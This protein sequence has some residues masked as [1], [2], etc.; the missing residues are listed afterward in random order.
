[1]SNDA[2][3]ER[4]RAPRHPAKVPLKA[5][6]TEGNTGYVLSGESVNLSERGVMFVVDAPVKVGSAIEL[7]FVMPPEIVGDFPMKIRCT[8]RVVRVDNNAAGGG[9]T[10]VAAHIERYETIVAE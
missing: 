1:M 8:A 2:N 6:P 5:R 10:G 3:D 7:S 4:R 9:K